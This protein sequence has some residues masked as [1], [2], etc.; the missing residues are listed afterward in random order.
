[1]TLLVLTLSLLKTG[2]IVLIFLFFLIPK[3]KF[4]NNK[5][6][7]KLIFISILCG[8]ILSI[9]WVLLANNW[10]IETRSVASSSKQIGFILEN[11]IRY[12][13]IIYIS[14]IGYRRELL[15]QLIGRLGWLD[16]TLPS[17]FKYFYL[18]ILLFLSGIT[19][20][21]FKLWQRILLLGVSSTLTFI[22]ITLI[23]L[24]WSGVGAVS[25][26]GL[27]GRYFFVPAIGLLLSISGILSNF[28]KIKNTRHLVLIFSIFSI[29]MTISAL[30]QR[31]YI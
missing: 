16:V 27:Q 10:H 9:S 20:L 5:N 29:F 31:Y 11:P 3:A 23:Y 22:I 28:M 2:Y 17:W 25:L 4:D 6:W 14:L 15:E 19:Q 1:L 12:F 7:Y 24:T 26:E 13:Q 8:F 18:F 21:K 30:L